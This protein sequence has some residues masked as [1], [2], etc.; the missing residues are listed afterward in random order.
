M[1]CRKRSI[2]RGGF[3]LIELYVVV[4]IIAVLIGMLLPAIAKVREAA[5]RV[6]CREQPETDRSGAALL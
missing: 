5:A 3:T 4:A 6:K 1:V 2:G